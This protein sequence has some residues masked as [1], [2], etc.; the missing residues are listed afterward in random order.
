MLSILVGHCYFLRFD[1]K[2]WQRAKPYP[3]LATLQVAARLRHAGHAVTIFDAMLAENTGEFDAQLRRDSPQV[4]VLYEDN[5]NYLSKMCLTA[6]RA[7]ACRMIAA[8][9]RGGA[10]VIVAGSDASDAPQAYLAAGAEVVLLGE[11]LATLS[12]LVDRLD[13]CATV[14]TQELVAGLIGVAS[15]PGGSGTRRELKAPPLQA[16]PAELPAWDLIDVERYR[17]LWRAA[18]GYFSLN[19]AASRGCPF[20]CNWCAK[21]IWGNRYLQRPAADV[22]AEMTYLKHTFN[23]DHVWFVDDIFGFRVDW[24]TDFSNA[25][26]A[27]HAS[28]PFTIQTRADLVSSAMARALKGAQCREVWL[29][30]ES[31]SQRILDAMNKGTE[32]ADIPRARARLAEE[33]IRVGLFIQLGYLGEELEDILATRSLLEHSRPDDIG[34][35]VS[36]PLPGTKFYDLV[37]EQLQAKTHW[38]ESN[39]LEMMFEGTYVSDFYRAVRD[40]FHD[41]VSIDNL[42]R[43]CHDVDYRR[44]RRALEHRWENLIAN[45]ALYRVGSGARAP[46]AMSGRA[47]ATGA[48]DSPP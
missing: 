13:T 8:A 12:V 14:P 1:Q 7:A 42:H 27:S 29:G 30:A 37:R 23:P 19:I 9:R 4:V 15:E 38:Q 35:S 24:V 20:R 46:A 17:V 47:R 6:M 33:D 21:P 48:A 44:K 16:Y 39:D 18:H 45:E 2:Q 31:G 22:A 25:V 28:I 10:R 32:V 40:L 43:R 3:P 34:V 11:G 41:Q 26:H 5:F 36:Y